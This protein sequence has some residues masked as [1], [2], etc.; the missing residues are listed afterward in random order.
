MYMEIWN[1]FDSSTVAELYKQ[2]DHNSS[3]HLE[4]TVYNHT[5]MVFDYCIKTF[6]NDPMFKTLLIGC[7]YHDL[8]KCFTQTVK[9][10]KTH[11][12]NHETVGFFYFDDYNIF[13]LTEQE[14]LDVK[15]IIGYHDVYKYDI[16]KLMK[17]FSYE[18]LLM[19]LKFSECDNNGR[20]TETSHLSFNW[21]ELPKYDYTKVEF[22][23]KVTVLVGL[24]GSGKS[25]FAKDEVISRDYYIEQLP[26]N[27]YSEKWKYANDNLIQSKINKQFDDKLKE[28]VKEEINFTVDKTNLSKK[29]RNKLLNSANFSKYFIEMVVFT[30][31][32]NTCINR[33]SQGKVVSKE[34]IEKFVQTANLPTLLECDKIIYI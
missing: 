11:F 19:L 23:P 32:V 31:S 28:L 18:D 29:S 30:T 17:M 7:L 34:V 4:G 6:S 16:N 15:K 14:K 25:T 20:I 9:D 5:K 26:G 24:P 3:Y 13:D 10:N 21:R 27:S 8:G 1:K 12:Y 22:N 2:F 33:R